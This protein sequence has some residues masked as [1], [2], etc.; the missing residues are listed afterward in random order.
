MNNACLQ[1]RGEL[2]W[3]SSSAPE[4]TVGSAHYGSEQGV[5]SPEQTAALSAGTCTEKHH[6]EC[7]VENPESATELNV[8]GGYC[9]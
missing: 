6:Q 9:C 5:F 4:E 3:S 1:P 8:C 2:L 7:G